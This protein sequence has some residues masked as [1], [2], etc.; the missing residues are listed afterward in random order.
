L[1]LG[2]ISMHS[3]TVISIE[4]CISHPFIFAIIC[5]CENE[6]HANI[7]CGDRI[8]SVNFVLN[9]VLQSCISVSMISYKSQ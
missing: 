9:K 4:F 2:N 3:A 1:G 7:L 6:S 5:K 8:L